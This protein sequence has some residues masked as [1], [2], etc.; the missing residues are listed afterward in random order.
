MFLK[1]AKLFFTPELLHLLFLPLGTY[2]L[3]FSMADF[4]ILQ[5]IA[6]SKRPCWLLCPVVLYH[7]PLLLSF[8]G[9]IISCNFPVIS[10]LVYRLLPP[11]LP[12]WNAT[13]ARTL[14]VLFTI[15]SSVVLH[16]L[17][18]IQISLC[19]SLYPAISLCFFIWLFLCMSCSPI[20]FSWGAPIQPLIPSLQ[21]SSWFTEQFKFSWA[22]LIIPSLCSYTALFIPHPNPSSTTWELFIF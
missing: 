15:I 6:S 12:T 2:F 14:P 18:L 1:H 16:C 5:V 7:T 22:K 17:L 19:L 8:T 11:T 20:P 13:R 9:F 21:V 4:L 3:V 10:L